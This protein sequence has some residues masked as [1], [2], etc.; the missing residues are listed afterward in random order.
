MSPLPVNIFW[1]FHQP[2]IPV[3]KTPQA[4]QVLHARIIVP[5]HSRQH[6]QR[7]ARQVR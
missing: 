4:L 1:P 5:L 2:R 6:V 3:A 7:M